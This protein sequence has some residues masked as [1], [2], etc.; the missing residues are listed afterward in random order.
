MLSHWKK[1]TCFFS[2]RLRP[3]SATDRKHTMLANFMHYHSILK[4]TL[5]FWSWYSTSLKY[6]FYAK[7]T[8]PPLLP[9]LSNPECNCQGTHIQWVEVI[10]SASSVD[11]WRAQWAITTLQHTHYM[12]R[13]LQTTSVNNSCNSGGTKSVAPNDIHFQRKHAFDDRMFTIT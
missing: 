5:L 8:P 7:W 6:Q 10:C 12:E 3:H 13:F 2:H 11:W 1:N 4:A 9:L